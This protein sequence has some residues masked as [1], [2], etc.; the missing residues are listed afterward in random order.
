[1]EAKLYYTAP[2][3]E[4]FDEVQQAAI[5][6]WSTYD[7]THGYSTEKINRVT[8]LEN[9]EDNFMVIF[10]MFDGVN[11]KKLLGKLSEDARREIILRLFDGGE[12][13]SRLVDM[14]FDSNIP[15]G[16]GSDGSYKGY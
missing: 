3:Q 4:I 13:V 8:A 9:V 1:M 14:Y 11:Q 7:D 12:D 15:T 5:R 6:I 2:S 16:F 10:A